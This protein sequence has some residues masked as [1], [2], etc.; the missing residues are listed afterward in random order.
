M[1]AGDKI[2]RL[3]LFQMIVSCSR[4]PIVKNQ[5]RRDRF[6]K[7]RCSLPFKL[8]CDSRIAGIIVLFT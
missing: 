6:I 7:R 1:A 3:T 2:T 4:Q 5:K 8:L